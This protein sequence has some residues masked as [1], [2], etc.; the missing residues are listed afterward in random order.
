[1][2]D[3]LVVKL[4]SLST[5]EVTICSWSCVCETSQ[6]QVAFDPIGRN[7]DAC[8]PKQMVNCSQLQT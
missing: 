1:M 4:Q 8:G 5:D 6:M 3:I 7:I 2:A